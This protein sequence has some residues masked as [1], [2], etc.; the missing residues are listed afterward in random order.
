M[1]RKILSKLGQ[2]G[3]KLL[4]Y[5]PEMKEGKGIFPTSFSLNLC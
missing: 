5:V 4:Q 2:F 3:L 1:E